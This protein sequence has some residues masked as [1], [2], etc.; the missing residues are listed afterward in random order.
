MTK[1]RQREWRGLASF[2]SNLAM[3]TSKGKFQISQS[4][5]V[6][7]ED[8]LELINKRKKADWLMLLKA[9]AHYKAFHKDFSKNIVVK[10]VAHI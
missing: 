3:S 8:S 1:A 5:W 7:C 4:D 9:L 2:F 10:I 6:V